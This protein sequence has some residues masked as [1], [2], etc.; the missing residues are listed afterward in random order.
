LSWHRPVL[1]DFSLPVPQAGF[2]NQNKMNQQI[3]AQIFAEQLDQIYT[4]YLNEDG[5]IDYAPG[6]CGE[7]FGFSKL[8]DWATEN[9]QLD[10]IHNEETKKRLWVAATKNANGWAKRFGVKQ[11]KERIK[12][13]AVK[14][15]K[16]ELVYKTLV[17]KLNAGEP[18]LSIVWD[19]SGETVKPRK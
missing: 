6:R 2:F 1:G 9:K 11:P 19:H 8:Y 12:N 7:F 17:D 16:S 15:Y 3:L 18:K 13:I 10:V 5:K 14:F 4:S